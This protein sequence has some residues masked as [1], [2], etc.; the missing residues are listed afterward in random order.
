MGKVM[1]HFT[2]DEIRYLS[3]LVGLEVDEWENSGIGGNIE[4]LRSIRG[5]LMT[6]LVNDDCEVAI[7]E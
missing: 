4:R 3:A 7:D 2:K 5:R 1:I 6:W